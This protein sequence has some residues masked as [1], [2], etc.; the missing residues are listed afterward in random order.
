MSHAGIKHLPV[1]CIGQMNF[2][3]KEK[4]SAPHILRF[5]DGQFQYFIISNI[6]LKLSIIFP[7][8][9]TNAE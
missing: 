6:Q 3:F 2:A 4:D 8:L 5:T 9:H 1:P 7:V